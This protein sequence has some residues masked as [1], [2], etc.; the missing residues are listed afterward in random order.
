MAQLKDRAKTDKAVRAQ[1]ESDPRRVLADMGFNRVIQNKLLE[2][3][4]RR[5]RWT[6][7][8]QGFA[9]DCMGCTGCCCSGCS[10]SH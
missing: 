9:G 2:E 4:G 10:Y 5:V 6:A 1:W 3:E 7:A 8:E